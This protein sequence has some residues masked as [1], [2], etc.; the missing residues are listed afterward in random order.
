L[1]YN[2]QINHLIASK[3]KMESKNWGGQ[4]ETDADYEGG[5]N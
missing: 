1:L 2:K 3:K 4:L 5:D